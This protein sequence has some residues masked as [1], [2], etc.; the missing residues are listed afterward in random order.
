MTAV[1][2]TYH[3]IEHGPA[4]LC[5]DPDAFRAHVDVLHDAGAVTL[6]VSQLAEG[7]RDGSLPAC[8]VALTFDDGCASAVR[9]AAPLLAEHGMTATYFCVAGYLGRTNAWPSQPA[10]APSLSLASAPELAELGELGFE[11]G[12][13]GLEHVPLAQPPPAVLER[14][15][16]D[17]ARALEDAVGVSVRTFAYPYG[18]ASGHELRS[19]VESLFDAACG[20][21]PDR[22]RPGADL[23]ALPR[24][25][26]H[27]V[28]KPQLLAR[29]V[30]GRG[31]AYL[32][33]RRA[34]ARARRIVTGGS[35]VPGA[36]RA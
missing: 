35:A 24:I 30:A 33:T 9:V 16:V 21:R 15:L 26:A 6:T 32:A 22:V 11:I 31:A 4:P 36:A 25:D 10:S 34:A 3:A 5:L 28:R 13:H 8:A 2:L 1:I 29:I 19:K 7:L 23:Y 12:G 17:G 20:T 27:Y 14:E 18:I